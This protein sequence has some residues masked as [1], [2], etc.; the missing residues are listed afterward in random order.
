MQKTNC[1]KLDSGQEPARSRKK[2]RGYEIASYILIGSGAIILVMGLAALLFMGGF[3]GRFSVPIWYFSMLLC[4][5]VLG[6]VMV[7][8]GFSLF[9]Y[10]QEE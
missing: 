6:L 7:I 9:R 2:A 1:D 5:S 10:A 3:F 4:Q 8:V